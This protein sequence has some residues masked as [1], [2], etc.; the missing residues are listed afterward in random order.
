MLEFVRV[1]H[2]DQIKSLLNAFDPQRQTW[3]V[4]DLKSKQEIQAECVARFG[5]FTDDSILRVSDFW[6]LWIRRLKPTLKVVSSDFIRS[7]VQLFV[8]QYGDS[9][10][11]SEAD[12]STLEKYVQELAPIILHPDS[13]SVLQEWLQVQ[14]RPRKWQMWYKMARVCLL[15]IVNEKKVIDVKWSAAYLQSLNLQALQ[16]PQ[17][18]IVDLGTELTSVEMGLFKIFSQ[19]QKVQIYVPYPDW[20]ERFP[21][22]LK[23]YS[24]NF[25]YGKT[26]D[27]PVE[28]QKKTTSKEFV[29]LSTQLAEVK[30]AVAQVRRWLEE[31]ISLSRIAVIGLQ[32]EDYWPVLQ[33]YLDEEG[34][35]YQKDTVAS[36]N[37]LSDVQIF[38][39]HLKSFTQDVSFESLQQKV[40]QR[41][42]DPQIKFEKFK[43]LFNQLFDEEDLRRDEK[44]KSLFYKRID[45][46]KDLSRDEF[47][48]ILLQ[49][50]SDLPEGA[51]SE[52][53]FELLF[54]DFL[55]QSLDTV[56]SFSSWFQFF[57]SRLSRKE[58]KISYASEEGIHVLALM[59]AQM[60]SADHRIYLG[61]YEEAFRIQRKSILPL[62][63]IELLKNQFDLAIPYPEESHLDF[64]LRWQVEGVYHKVI[65]TSP[66]LSF[67]AEPLTP[68]LYFLEN[69]PQSEICNPMPTRLDE[70]QKYFSAHRGEVVGSDYQG[71]NQ[72]RLQEDLHGVG[73]VQ[74]Q[75]SVFQKL[76]VSEVES[77]ARCGFKTLASKGFRLRDLPEVSIDLDPRQ[78]G[79]VV[80][81]LFEHL[82]V[83]IEKANYD[84]E[85]TRQFLQIKRQELGLFVNEDTFWVVQLNKMMAV[86][87]KFYEF[88][89]FR[90][91]QFKSFTEKDFEIYFDPEQKKFTVEKPNDGFLIRGRI[92]R[93][94]QIRG[95]NQYLIYDYKSSAAQISN[96]RNWLSEYQFQLLIY[97]MAVEVS[98]FKEADVKGML[99]YLYKNFSIAKGLID[100][101]VALEK[102][103]LSSR[104]GSLCDEEGIK[105]L[106]EGFI[107]LMA[108][109]FTH[110][111]KGVFTPAP[112]EKELCND[113][114]WRK[115]CRV[116]HLM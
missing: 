116:K 27:L 100:K 17:E 112:F 69:S 21:F 19:K 83:Q 76:A 95:T 61:L 74:I 11:L 64:N 44:I 89:R 68:C 52:V 26:Q 41:K 115:L 108:E 99:Y 103:S 18:M 65:L 49:V 15:Y 28:S 42:A 55:G 46:S 111:K 97:L 51:Y 92:D 2:P 9:L 57:K 32:I 48:A 12:Q 56:M 94:D 93:I 75:H 25:G 107:Q 37:S 8:S 24:E 54:K 72:K 3:I 30:W 96:Y 50:W 66:H 7:L 38:L 86:A 113:C 29:R 35:P 40:F 23:T 6:R 53:L 16:W 80:H 91:Q 78:K 90:V 104:I 22:L 60:T 70:V 87:D 10:E 85:Q 36:V 82:I 13:D 81:A 102:L 1:K 71:L 34:V 20:H 31:G 101:N 58:M 106:K 59:S 77:Y 84:R 45:F 63:D 39:A 73:Q 67:A 79:V 98:L 110:L 4:S 33:S 47:M 105:A 43:A 114:D 109:K 62:S 88:E 5:F 14:E